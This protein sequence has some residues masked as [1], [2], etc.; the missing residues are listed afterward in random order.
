MD[1]EKEGSENDVIFLKNHTAFFKG[2]LIVVPK[3]YHEMHLESTYIFLKFL[4]F[5]LDFLVTIKVFIYV[6]FVESL[7]PLC[8]NVCAVQAERSLEQGERDLAGRTGRAIS[9]GLSVFRA[10]RAGLA[11]LSTQL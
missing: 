4:L 9:V 7:S 1:F 3:F 10:G 11:Y 5:L 8:E 2:S 6:R